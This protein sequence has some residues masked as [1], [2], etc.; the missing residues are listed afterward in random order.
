MMVII[1]ACWI[2]A[3]CRSNIWIT[4]GNVTKVIVTNTLFW[5]NNIQIAAIWSCSLLVII[6]VFWLIIIFVTGHDSW[7]AVFVWYITDKAQTLSMKIGQIIVVKWKCT[8]IGEVWLVLIK[9]KSF[10]QKVAV[11]EFAQRYRVFDDAYS[12]VDFLFFRD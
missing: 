11:W 4:A 8:S 5:M 1:G 6:V 12:S 7:I 9:L 3:A 10:F 2:L